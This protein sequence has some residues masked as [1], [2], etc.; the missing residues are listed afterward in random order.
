MTREE[1]DAVEQ[2]LSEFVPMPLPSTQRKALLALARQGLAAQAL[3]H[4]LTDILSSLMTYDHMRQRVDRALSAFRATTSAGGA[5]PPQ[6]A[7]PFARCDRCPYF[8]ACDQQGKC[9]AL[10]GGEHPDA[11]RD[12]PLARSLADLRRNV[13]V[14]A[15]ALVEFMDTEKDTKRMRAMRIIATQALRGSP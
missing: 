9:L 4:E 12:T 10:S 11:G 2:K 3:A 13:A 7:L 6:V 1:L 5:K 15:A 14:I 8:A